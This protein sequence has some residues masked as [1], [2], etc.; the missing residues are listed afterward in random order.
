MFKRFEFSP[1]KT[2]FAILLATVMLKASAWQWERYKFKV[3]LIEQLK[4]NSTLVAV[5]LLNFT[6]SF[7]DPEALLHKK[8]SAKGSYDFDRQAIIINRTYSTGSGYWLL[9]PF[10]L[11]GTNQA[12]IVSRGFIPFEDRTP[13]TWTKYN[14]SSGKIEGVVQLSVS[15]KILTPSNPKTGDGQPFAHK[16]LYPEIDAMARQLPYS[17]IEG[18]FIQRLSEEK[19]DPRS[20]VYPAEDVKIDVPPEVHYG[21]TFEWI[22]LAFATLSVSFLLQ[23]FPRNP[24]AKKS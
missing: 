7:S 4:S 19:F 20:P 13:D 10:K 12:V 21:Y 11:E 2:I 8:V 3:E 17:V 9:A 1:F 24:K 16:F 15:K 5:P 14:S 23:A 18:F 6:D 22:I